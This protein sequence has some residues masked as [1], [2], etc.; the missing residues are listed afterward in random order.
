MKL[1]RR[2]FLH[3]AVGAAAI[4]AASG[5]AKAEVYPS[6][7]ITMIVPIAPG[8]GTDALARILAEHMRGTLGQSIIVENITGAGGTIGTAHVARAAPDGY[9]LSVGNIGTHVIS[10]ATYPNIQ[11]H[12][13]K[14]FEP[15][16]LIATSAYWLIAKNALPPKDLTELIVWLKANPDKASA[17]MVGTGG[18][19]QIA[20]TY[21]QQKTG[22]RFQFV[23]YRGAAPAIQDLMAGHVDLKFDPVA[24]S[25]P[26]VRS[27][28]LKAY[29]V[30]G[31]SRWSA[32]SEI[33]TAD[34]LGVPGLDVTFW[35]GLWAPKGTPK[36]V[37]AKLNAAVADAFADPTVRRKITDLGAE[38]PPREQ[39]TTEAFGVFH[40]AEIDK[41]WS[42]IKA[43]GIKAE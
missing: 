21:F 40:K 9:T 39:Q 20:G 38:I 11:Y 13:L 33:P 7:T 5:V 25:L 37:I 14:D 23:P 6:R 30:F 32:A 36:P 34:E 4:P 22:T 10:P 2:R 31:K 12:P 24:A 16:A 29:A 41:W 27:G 28:Q 15:V 35:Y 43:A 8:V 26:Y 1:P 18:L 19:D 3:V 42:F 17:A